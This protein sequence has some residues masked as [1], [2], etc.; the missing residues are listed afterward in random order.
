MATSLT[1]LAGAFKMNVKQIRF[2]ASTSPERPPEELNWST[3]KGPCGRFVEGLEV[4]IT[5]S[6]VTIRQVSYKAD[7]IALLQEWSAAAMGGDSAKRFDIGQAAEENS[8]SREIKTFTYKL[9]DVRAVS[10][11]LR[12]AEV[13]T[14][15]LYREHLRGS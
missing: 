12:Q 4:A 15:H 7:P 14:P 11:H 13:K 10:K 5:L 9:E 2:K 6:T 1:C 8:K 3:G